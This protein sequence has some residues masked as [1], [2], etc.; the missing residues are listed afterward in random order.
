MFGIQSLSARIARLR[1]G[2]ASHVVAGG[3]QLLIR[4]NNHNH[5]HNPPQ[6]VSPQCDMLALVLAWFRAQL[7]ADFPISD[8]GFQSSAGGGISVIRPSEGVDFKF[9]RGQSQFCVPVKLDFA[10]T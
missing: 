7:R 6:N 8:I 3:S 1:A 10:E 4:Y 9:L 2:P 5:N